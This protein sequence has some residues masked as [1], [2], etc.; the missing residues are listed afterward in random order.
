MGRKKRERSVTLELSFMF[1]KD[2]KATTH[3][4]VPVCPVWRIA[5]LTPW[6]TTNRKPGVPN[7]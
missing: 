6:A 4:V 5:E 7:F 1:S 2:L 3:N